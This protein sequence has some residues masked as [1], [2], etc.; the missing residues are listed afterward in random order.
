MTPSWD[1]AVVKYRAES[2]LN[3]Y[4]CIVNRSRPLCNHIN[5][6]VSSIKHKLHVD[7]VVSLPVD[8]LYLILSRSHNHYVRSINATDHFREASNLQKLLLPPLSFQLGDYKSYE[9]REDGN[10]SLYH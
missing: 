3:K 8:K 2:T 6:V 4:S 5:N 1:D 9:L 10:V 7:A